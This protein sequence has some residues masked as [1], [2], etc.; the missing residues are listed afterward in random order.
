MLADSAVS[1]DVGPGAV[2]LLLPLVGV[3]VLIVQ[4]HFTK[5]Q[6]KVNAA[7]AEESAKELKPNGGTSLRDAVDRI[8]VVVTD[9]ARRV[10][11]LEHERVETHTTTRIVGAEHPTLP[12][13][14]PS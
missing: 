7:S 14:P 12:P 8:E 11:T 13:P 2:A 1:F 5:K 9:L 10:G 4:N 3:I 6:T